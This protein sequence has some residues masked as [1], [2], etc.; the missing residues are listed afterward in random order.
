MEIKNLSWKKIAGIVIV[1][2]SFLGAIIT[3]IKGWDALLSILSFFK[4]LISEI[5]KFSISTIGRDVLLFVV[6]VGTLNWL[7]RRGRKVR[8]V[9]QTERIVEKEDWQFDW[10]LKHEFVL[11]KFA[12]GKRSY[13]LLYKLYEK[14]FSD[15]SKLEFKV[16]KEDLEEADLIRFSHKIFK[17]KYYEATRKGREY[18]LKGLL[19]EMEKQKIASKY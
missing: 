17:K 7:I 14:E 11:E 4:N 8:T 5:L 12:E 18:A 2:L 13:N 16:I 19:A 3:I 9:P 10:N 6:V 1:L 15:A